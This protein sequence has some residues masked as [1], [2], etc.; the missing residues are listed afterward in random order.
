MERS[1]QTEGVF[2]QLCCIK[3]NVAGWVV[4]Q[5]NHLCK[6][7]TRTTLIT[8]SI[9]IGRPELRNVLAEKLG[10]LGLDADDRAIVLG[11]KIKVGGNARKSSRTFPFEL[12]STQCGNSCKPQ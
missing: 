2:D 1:C 11:N 9:C 10:A 7:R 5:T 8:D 6:P 12:W 3:P 4:S